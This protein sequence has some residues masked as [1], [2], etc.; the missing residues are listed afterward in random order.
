VIALLG[1]IIALCL[2]ATPG[3]AAPPT[4]MSQQ[5]VD[6]I[7]QPSVVYI[8]VHAEGYV[9]YPTASGGL[10]WSDLTKIDGSCTGFVVSADGNVITAG[11]CADTEMAKHSI[12]IQFLADEVSN[13]DL[14]DT[15][16]QGLLND[17]DNWKV[18]GKANGAPIVQTWTVYLPAATSGI[19]TARSFQ[20]TLIEDRPL[21]KGDVALLKTTATNLPVL[22]MSP[23]DPVNGD[24]VTAV[25]YPADA[26]KIVDPSLNPTFKTGTVSGIQTQHGAPFVQHSAP[27]LS[28][29]SGG[30]LAN[31]TGDGIGATS[32][33]PVDQTGSRESGFTFA[34]AGSTIK[35]IMHSHGVNNTLAP[36]DVAYRQG[37]TAYFAGKYHAAEKYFDTALQT[38]PSHQQAQKF[39]ADSVAKFDQDKQSSGMPLWVLLVIGAGGL[40][41]IG[42]IVWFFLRRRRNKKVVAAEAD[43]PKPGETGPIPRLEPD[44]SQPTYFPQ[45]V[46]A[47]PPITEVTCPQCGATYPPGAKYCANDGSALAQTTV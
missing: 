1:A 43:L 42:G 23:T 21:D 14:T 11:H 45:S 44:G 13:G 47:M 4:T 15:E 2:T 7:V 3:N 41:V 10:K 16:A 18:E 27:I 5:Q 40:V 39:K 17:V 12:R 8:D 46:V 30:P 32:S 6:A 9:Q 28:G 31:A 24:P 38:N 25:G 34:A 33:T 35:D 20:A 37:L 36:A 29:M 22:L 19:E 26:D